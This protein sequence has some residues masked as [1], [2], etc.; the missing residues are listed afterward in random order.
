[1]M[2]ETR[3]DFKACTLRRKKGTLVQLLFHCKTR[4]W[5]VRK[6]AVRLREMTIRFQEK[7]N[8]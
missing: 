5:K 7:N 1:M 4:K 8:N 6:E 3:I 2:K